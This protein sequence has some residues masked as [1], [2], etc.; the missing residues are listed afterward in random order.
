M[1]R[2]CYMV[3]NHL[4][5]SILSVCRLISHPS[6]FFS[7]ARQML[8]A[9]RHTNLR[10]LQAL[11]ACLC[12][13]SVFS[14]VLVYYL[15]YHG[16]D[17]H[18]LVSVTCDWVITSM[19]KHE[20]VD[21]RIP[22]SSTAMIDCEPLFNRDAGLMGQ[23]KSYMMSNHKRAATPY[24]YIKATENCQIFRKE[25]GYNG[26]ATLSTQEEKDFPLAFSIMTYKDIEQ[27]ERLLRM[28]YRPQNYYCIHVDMKSSYTF[29]RAL[30]GIASCFSNVFVASKRVDVAW[31]EYTVL[32][33]DLVCM[34]DLLTYTKWKYI[35]N[36]T[37]QEFPLKT[38]AEMVK[39][40]KV[41]NGANNL[42]ATVRKRDMSRINYHYDGIERTT[43]RKSP[44]PHNITAVKGSVHIL[45]SRGYVDY[46]INSKIAN[47]FL[48]W[49]KDT[50]YPDETFFSTMNH[51]PHLKVP[52]SYLG[53]PETNPK[54][55][56]FLAR[57]KL[58][59]Y[60][61]DS[62]RCGG[63]WQRSICVYGLSDLRHLISRKEFFANKFELDYEYVAFDCME[64]YIFNLAREH[65]YRPQKI[66]ISYYEN[67]P[68]Y[69]NVIL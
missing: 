50:G 18:V 68:F 19:I 39:I 59:R 64:E 12:I 33:G 9:A 6:E 30:L 60:E 32:E 57:Y 20:M 25:M 56:P 28:L 11:F 44:P 67:L 21:L 31:G 5:R 62:W 17:S 35:I 10:K 43:V 52:G 24:F 4:G 55:Y 15:A 45:A 51:N 13:F 8:E 54:I 61:R 29:Y 53:E 47:D 26:M 36:L 38:N 14:F 40:L 23:I 37:G 16:C 65:R 2:L 1:R 42:E 58:W 7:E 69:K 41:F 63:Y 22:V 66:N 34:R 49:V 27:V 48:E 3:R 46:I